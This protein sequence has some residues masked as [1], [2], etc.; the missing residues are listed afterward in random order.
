MHRTVFFNIKAP[1]VVASA[2]FIISFVFYYFNAHPL[3]TDPDVPWHIA[4]GDL[5]RAQQGLPLT[6]PWSFASENT[7]WFNLAWGWDVIISLI[8]DIFGLEGIF[9]FSISLAALVIALLCVVLEKRGVHED[10]IKVI[11]LLAGFVLWHS[12][13][14]RPQLITFMMVLLFY[15]FLASDREAKRNKA[16]FILLPILM[17]VWTNL[18]GGFLA[19]FIL[20]GGYGIEALVQ[21]DRARAIRYALMGALWFLCIFVT[22][23]GWHIIPGTLATLNSPITAYISEWHPFTY[24]THFGLTIFFLVFLFVSNLQRKDI[25]LADKILAFAWLLA[26]LE[27]IRSFVI[28][29]LVAAPYMAFNMQSMMTLNNHPMSAKENVRRNVFLFSIICYVAILL[30]GD[31]LRNRHD[32]T[33]NERLVP[34]QEIKYA[35]RFYPH[36]NFLNDYDFGGSLIYYGEGDMKF[37][38]DGRAGTAFNAK[39]L[40]SYLNFFTSKPGWE[41]IVSRYNVEG[42]FLKTSSKHNKW[43]ENHKD[44][45]WVYS[46]DVANI[47]VKRGVKQR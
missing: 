7:P 30:Q 4:A 40:K 46:G 12:M 21:K 20:L 29:S 38:M 26:S 22:P 14:A 47:Y 11:A 15:H 9:L 42:F 24:G 33:M 31:F 13:F 41:D 23:L 28:F 6:D 45:K 19:G 32:M 16:M 2:A 39:A 25:P 43:L 36:V 1:S 37:F 44:W 3:F 17:I 8:N 18:H 27:S 10:P 34:R 5:I 35:K